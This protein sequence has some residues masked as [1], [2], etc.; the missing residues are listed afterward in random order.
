MPF[1]QLKP[2]FFTLI[3]ASSKTTHFFC[4]SDDKRAAFSFCLF[5]TLSH[6]LLSSNP[7]FIVA[8]VLSL[9]RS[10]RVNASAYPSLPAQKAFPYPVIAS[11]SAFLIFFVN[12]TQI[13]FTLCVNRAP[14]TVE[15]HINSNQAAIL[16]KKKENTN[17]NRTVYQ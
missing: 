13:F 11:R 15:I 3:L 17:Q 1:R 10:L 9:S 7:F 14:T 2:A 4:K 12:H 5:L 8:F 16:K 6:S